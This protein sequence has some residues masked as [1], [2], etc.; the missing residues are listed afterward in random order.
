M[1]VF[2]GTVSVIIPIYNVDKYLSQCLSSIASQT[3]KNLE[4]ICINDGSTDRSLEIINSFAAND[5]RFVIIDK[6]NEG[7]GAGCNQG[8]D[9]AT[10]KWISIVEPDDWIEPTMYED[11][12]S[13]A[14]KFENVDI[15]KTP[16]TD[17]TGWD[18]P[19]SQ[20]TRRCP[21]KGKIGT[22]KK[23]FEIAEN[24]ILLECHPSIW[25][26][27]YRRDFLSD[28]KIRFM[29]IPGAGWADNPFLIETLC[30]A[31]NIVY[32]DRE[33]YNY[34]CDLP[35]ST[36][37][38]ANAN[39]IARPFDRWDDMLSIINR[40]HITD[41]RILA[42]HYIRGFN[43]AYGA[44]ADDGWDNSIVQRRTSHMFQS[45][46][47]D[48]VARIPEISPSR[49]EL[50]YSLRGEECPSISKLP[51]LRHLLKETA[52]TIKYDGIHSVFSRAV[53]LATRR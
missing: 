16:W 42:A 28:N 47:A 23:T 3:F 7:Y 25:S 33:F 29:E 43:Y 1:N 18:D 51:W 31:K 24:P 52:I 22:S 32:L 11:M 39:A 10:G 14:G 17:I 49:K 36:H 37:N 41:P 2:D 38:H 35:G 21:F 5:S 48:I 26:A 40:L 19:F 12:V 20:G 46:N 4:I 15:V 9:R 6:M 30:Q 50:F 13:F 34:R 45:M 8:I 53:R 44:I 27:I